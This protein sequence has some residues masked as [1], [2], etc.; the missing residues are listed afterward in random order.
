MQKKSFNSPD[1]TMTPPKTKIE[2]VD[3]DNGTIMRSTFEPGWKWSENIKPTAGTDSC[4]M[5]HL[6][7]LT[8]GQLKVVMDDGTEMDFG[9]GDVADIPPGHD[10]WV[11]GDEAMVGI[12]A[13]GLVPNKT[14]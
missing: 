12:D 2:V 8:S 9:P 11:V 13:G 5:H 10:A 14:E 7:C 3:V 1:Q 6:L 4:Q